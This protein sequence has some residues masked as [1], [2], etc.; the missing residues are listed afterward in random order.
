[1]AFIRATQIRRETLNCE[2]PVSWGSTSDG[3]NSQ[4]IETIRSAEA[5]SFGYVLQLEAVNIFPLMHTFILK[6]D[7]DDGE[8]SKLVGHYLRTFV[9]YVSTVHSYSSH[10]RL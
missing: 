1:M 7:K 6:D 5:L 3:L 9:C 8:V 2:T 4:A 10:W